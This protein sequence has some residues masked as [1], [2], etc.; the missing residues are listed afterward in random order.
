MTKCAK[1]CEITADVVFRG[2]T[3]TF[4]TP[5]DVDDQNDKQVDLIMRLQRDWVKGVCGWSVQNVE[6]YNIRLS[7]H[8]HLLC[9]L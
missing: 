4:L 7:I 3:Y 9:R 2:E 6:G 8:Q 5:K 1:K